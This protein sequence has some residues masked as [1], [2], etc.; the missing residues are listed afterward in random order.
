[1]RRD[2]KAI[3]AML[4]AALLLAMLSITACSG[5]GSQASDFNA[6]TLEGE[7]FGLAQKRG[8]VVALYFMA[9]Y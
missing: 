3:R 8:E 5:P 2:E 6:T 9:A 7:Q 1:M 4:P